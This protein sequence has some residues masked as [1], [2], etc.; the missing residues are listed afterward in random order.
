MKQVKI[1]LVLISIASQAQ[2]QVNEEGIPN[3]LMSMQ[4]YEPQRP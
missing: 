2:S 3:T 1:F 4:S